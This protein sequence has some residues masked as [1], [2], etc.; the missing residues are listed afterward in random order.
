MRR[1]IEPEVARLASMRVTPE[2]ARQLKDALEAEKLLTSSALEEVER[3]TTIHFILA[4]MCGNRFLE[5]LVR[6]VV[7]LSKK[8]VEMID[9]DPRHLHPEGMNVPVVEAVLS[10]D[11]ERAAREMEKHAIEFGANLI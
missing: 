3:K 5:A 1:L 7:G 8:V 6:S 9:T 11:P 2:Y 10:G 4:E